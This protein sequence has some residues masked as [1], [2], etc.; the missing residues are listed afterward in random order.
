[1]KTKLLFFAS[2]LSAYSIAQPTLVKDINPTATPGNAWDYINSN[3]GVLGTT[4]YMGTTNGIDGA[5]L[6]KTDGTSA[7][8]SMLKNINTYAGSPQ[9]ISGFTALGV[10]HYFLTSTY[11]NFTLWKTTGTPTS[12]TVVKEIP[13]NCVNIDVLGSNLILMVQSA[14]SGNL[15]CWKS[16]GTTAGTTLYKTLTSSATGANYRF[17]KFGLMIMFAF[18]TGF[19]GSQLYKTDGTAAGTGLVKTI[20]SSGSA[21]TWYAYNLSSYPN[22][23]NFV[24]FQSKL[25]FFADDGFSI[26]I[27]KTDGTS[28]GTV[29]AIDMTTVGGVVDESSN[30]GATSTRLYFYSTAGTAGNELHESDGTA[31]GTGVYDLDPGSSGLNTP[32]WHSYAPIRNYNSS[33]VFFNDDITAD[34]FSVNATAGAQDLLIPGDNFNFYSFWSGSYLYAPGLSSGITRTDGTFAGTSTFATTL[35]SA[36]NFITFG[37]SIYFIGSAG[38]SYNRIY[39]TN[40]TTAGTVIQTAL[41]DAINPGGESSNINQFIKLN[42]TTALFSA[43]NGTNGQELWKTDATTGGTTL[44]KDIN[45]GSASSNPTQFFLWGGMV[46][47]T[48][49]SSSGIELWK[50]DGTTAGTT[51]VKDIYV[52]VGDANPAGFTVFGA[53]LYFTA[54]DG[55]SNYELWKSDGTTAG[56]SM[57]KNI[58]AAGSSMGFVSYTGILGVLG[59]KLYF[60]ADNGTNG[61]EF[62]STDGTSAGTTLLKDI[63][64]GSLG[65]QISGGIIFGSNLYFTANEGTSGRE[66]WKSDGTSVGT[67]LLKDIYTGLS[68]SDPN[69]FFQFGTKFYFL[70]NNGTN[71]TEMWT[72]DGTAA[73]TAL[74]KDVYSGSFSSDISDIIP[75]GSYFFFFA[76]YGQELWKSNGTT[77]GTTLIS[78]CNQNTSIKPVLYSGNLYFV[79]N[80]E[81][82]TSNGTTANMVAALDQTGTSFLSYPTE[83]CSTSSGLVVSLD[84]QNDGNEIW[85]Y[86]GTSAT[87][88][89]NIDA[90][91]Q[92]SYAHYFFGLGSNLLYTATNSTQGYELYKLSGFTTSGIEELANAN[93]SSTESPF[94]IYPVPSN[95]QVNITA[96]DNKS[97]IKVYEIY[98]IQGRLIDKQEINPNVTYSIDINEYKAGIYFIN[99]I[100]EEDYVY[101]SKFIKM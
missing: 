93:S 101:A 98:D 100:T 62:W 55:A 32:Y 89:G 39:K 7:G 47:F 37:S 67:T 16:D 4:M 99:I 8:T 15:E 17:T 45:T 81:V 86:N 70:A 27:W 31:A 46:Y 74:L 76:K 23:S 1:M 73:G 56:T 65:S 59:S 2:L 97:K 44:V 5:E 58:N 92:S 82:M 11:P 50:T 30:L 24:P 35:T 22:E 85:S 91:A 12:T 60:A 28:A 21:L 3:W 80:N 66:L 41:N 43:T 78:L 34:L 90:T 18:D 9:P 20:N 48:A 51:M 61:A 83:L 79:S 68:Y 38:T 64:S 69:T 14:S 49:T 84:N 42:S 94:V 63:Y 13:G 29:A 77:A 54:T 88:L 95:T 52:G 40:G 25:W 26:K 53:N 57:L 36:T 33:Y 19:T 87:L 96:K 6:W 10:N 72:S 75:N 71:G